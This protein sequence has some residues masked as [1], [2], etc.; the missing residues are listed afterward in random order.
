LYSSLRE[1]TS[2][3]FLVLLTSTFAFL[4]LTNCQW[5]AGYGDFEPESGSRCSRLPERKPGARGQ[6]LIRVDIPHGTCFWIDQHEVTVREYETWLENMPTDFDDWDVRC[7]WKSS[8]GPSDPSRNI[9]DSCGAGIPDSEDGFG[10]E[11]PIR[12]VDFCDAEAFCR[13]SGEE[14]GHLC[15]E[16]NAS[17]SF[18]PEA[19]PEQWEFACSNSAET[20]YPWGNE[21]ISS[22]DDRV[23]NVAQDELGSCIGPGVTTCG[24]ADVGVYRSCTTRDEIHDLIGNV[25]EWVFSCK[26]TNTLGDPN[27]PCKRYGG[28]YA[29]GLG[30]ATCSTIS[31]SVAL[32]KNQRAADLGFRCCV[33]LDVADEATLK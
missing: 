16:N 1:G 22:K 12:C 3:G 10:P 19:K 2:R 27:Q 30:A 9:L 18:E 7:A 17:S 5:V 26:K 21:P 13:T 14:R 24:P 25:A 29:Q 11:K 6:W 20:Q 32:A 8:I 33:E 15:W 28:S 31:S 23:C 4:A